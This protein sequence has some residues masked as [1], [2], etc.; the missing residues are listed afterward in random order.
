[1][2]YHTFILFAAFL[3]FPNVSS[4]PW[5]CKRYLFAEGEMTWDEARKF[6]DDNNLKMAWIRSSWDQKCVKLDFENHRMHSNKGQRQYWM[7]A[8]TPK[9]YPS[10]MA[11]GTGFK[12]LED[13][14][15]NGIY[16]NWAQNEPG[17]NK[18]ERCAGVDTW[19]KLS[20]F[21]H[22]CHQKFGVICMVY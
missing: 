22:T 17:K 4:Q 1:M 20:W 21:D 16:E 9:D 8:Y 13:R 10:H 6:C 19:R 15:L 7:G 11:H 5:H 14:S 2:V 18:N 3:A 12:W